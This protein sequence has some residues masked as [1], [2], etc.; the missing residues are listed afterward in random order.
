MLTF[1]GAPIQGVSAI[2]EK[3]T[4]LNARPGLWARTDGNIVASLS[5]GATQSDDPRCAA[6]F[7]NCVVDDRECNWFA[8]GESKDHHSSLA[9]SF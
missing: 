9:P 7:P 6:V 4:V 8:R 3:L 1:E 2:I 5:E